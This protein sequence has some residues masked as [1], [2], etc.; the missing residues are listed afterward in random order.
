MADIDDI[1]LTSSVFKKRTVETSD[2]DSDKIFNKFFNE[3]P[4]FDSFIKK[5]ETVL[6]C[7]GHALLPSV[8]SSCD[9]DC[10]TFYGRPFDRCECIAHANAREAFHFGT[11]FIHGTRIFDS[12]KSKTMPENILYKKAAARLLNYVLQ[13]TGIYDNSVG[14]LVISVNLSLLPVAHLSDAPEDG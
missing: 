14:W 9:A 5:F 3:Y 4:L 1:C 8:I 12:L 11:F 6:S 13:D 2:R 10:L 7:P